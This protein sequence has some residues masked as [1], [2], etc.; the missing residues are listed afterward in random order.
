M[1]GLIGIIF[2]VIW[3][4]TVIDILNAKNIQT[5]GKTLWIIG[6]ALFPLVGTLAWFFVGRE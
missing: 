1:N 6:V 4:F 2:L 3:I 5:L